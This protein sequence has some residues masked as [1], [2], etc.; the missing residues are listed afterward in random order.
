VSRRVRRPQH[1]KLPPF[2]DDFETIFGGEYGLQFRLVEMLKTM[3]NHLARST[4]AP[5]PRFTRRR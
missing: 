2:E 4:V 1:F 5:L 3:R